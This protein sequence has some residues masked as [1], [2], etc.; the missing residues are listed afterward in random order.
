[1]MS[2]DTHSVPKP[3][4]SPG[5]RR[6]LIC[7]TALGGGAH[8]IANDVSDEPVDV[9]V[10][11][12]LASLRPNRSVLLGRARVTGDLN[13]TARQF[14]L[15]QT[16]PRARNYC[17]KMVWSPRRR[18][19]LYL[20]ANHAAPHRLNDVWEFDLAR[21]RWALLYGPDLP[22]DYKGLG[23]DASDVV[24]Q[25]GVLQT[26]RGG[27]A[28]IGHTWG[29]ITFD[30][31]H[32]RVVFM[33][34]WVTDMDAA[35]AR[36]GGN[37]ATQ[38]RGPPL[39]SFEPASRRWRPILSDDPRPRWGSGGLLE[40]V[41]ELQGCVWHLNNWQLRQ[42]WLFNGDRESWRN[43]QA[44]RETGDF[45]EQAPR[46]EAMGY[47]DPGRRM[48]VAR[49]DVH[50]HRF[51]TLRAHW[52]RVPSMQAP[53]GEAPPPGHSARTAFVYDAA[54]RD[55]ILFSRVDRSLWRYTPDNA[56]WSRLAP[57]GPSI[58]EGDRPLMYADPA[59]AVVVVISDTV[60]WAYRV[61]AG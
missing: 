22:R 50:D 35:I 24:Y 9:S 54:T 10:L 56:R 46:A 41:P 14:D 44:N 25:D 58:P 16:G 33:N 38:Y 26:R 29:G 47:H 48:I 6:F 39:W 43:L 53:S 20:G 18:T 5:R 31:E 40:H 2:N 4:R 8:A 15:H 42:S 11:D 13:A 49:A 27:P 30:P 28:V 17:L 60:V 37:P 45:R 7:C 1:M 32:E 61:P 21:M 52:T 36:V 34:T 59:R 55:G 57:A 51:D 3:L 19:A 23:P 12:R